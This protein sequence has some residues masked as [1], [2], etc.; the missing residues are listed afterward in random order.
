MQRR[1]LRRVCCWFAGVEVRAPSACV[2][3]CACV[4]AC[5]CA[6]VVASTRPSPRTHLYILAR[7]NFRAACVPLFDAVARTF[8]FPVLPLL[9]LLLLLPPTVMT[10]RCRA[11]SRPQLL[12]ARRG[13]QR[14]FFC[15][16]VC[17]S[18]PCIV[19]PGLFC[20]S[21]TP[22]CAHRLAALVAGPNVRSQALFPRPRSRHPPVSRARSLP[23]PQC[24]CVR[25]ALSLP[26]PP[27]LCAVFAYMC[28]Q[29]GFVAVSQLCFCRAYVSAV[30]VCARRCSSCVRR[31]TAAAAGVTTAWRDADNAARKQRQQHAAKQQPRLEL[32]LRQFVMFAVLVYGACTSFSKA[33]RG[34]T[35]MPT[36]R[37]ARDMHARVAQASDGIRGA[38]VDV[39]WPAF[40][41]LAAC[42]YL[43]S[44]R[45]ASC[46]A[47]GTLGY[48]SYFGRA[49]HFVRRCRRCHCTVHRDH[50]ATRVRRC[51]RG[52]TLCVCIHTH[53]RM[54]THIARTPT[55]SLSLSLSS[56]P[57]ASFKVTSVTRR[58]LSAQNQQLAFLRVLVGAPR[59]QHL[60]PPHWR[61]FRLDV[62]EASRKHPLNSYAFARALFELA[63]A[64]VLSAQAA[65]QALYG[66]IPLS[67]LRS[68]AAA[69]RF[70]ASK[71]EPSS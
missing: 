24:M 6:C 36:G 43:T 68:A 30:L 44:Q 67:V 39:L 71:T 64:H 38:V 21:L 2:Y 16:R 62:L 20:G 10:R 32:S 17:A 34:W 7:G 40:A 13:E 29:M 52:S 5:V 35:P 59:P 26:P 9:L 56:T 33:F 54:R 61:A 23:H 66:V 69:A 25:R 41:R 47:I 42:E 53:G 27:C 65:A 51:E 48:R 55:R 49:C 12:A 57:L 11:P 46:G 63:D 28:A 1:R 22:R 70:E 37:L 8:V 60:V 15:A 19:W 45:C 18:A 31:P 3:V 4:R 50:N 58:F 14:N